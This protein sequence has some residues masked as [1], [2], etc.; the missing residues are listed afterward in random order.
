M[1]SNPSFDE[2]SLTNQLVLLAVTELERDDQIPVQ[3]HDVR[4]ACKNRLEDVDRSIGGTV[5]EAD[6][7]RS[8]YTLEDEGLVTEVNRQGR[9]PTGKGRPAYELAVDPKRVTKGIDD[10]LLADG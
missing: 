3:T 5:T 7:M 2:L 10:E 1:E 8:L 4:Q 6:V 9:S